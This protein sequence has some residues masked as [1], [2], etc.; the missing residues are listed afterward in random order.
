MTLQNLAPGG[1][2]GGKSYRQRGRKYVTGK[3]SPKERKGT[4]AET[5]IFLSPS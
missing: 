3:D 4:K 2:V 5:E 1:N